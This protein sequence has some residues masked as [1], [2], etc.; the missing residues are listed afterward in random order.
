MI[1][2]VKVGLPEDILQVPGNGRGHQLG[3]DVSPVTFLDLDGD[4]A[5]LL[6]G[7]DLGELFHKQAQGT[8]AGQE[9]D[10]DA[11]WR[12]GLFDHLFDDDGLLDDLF[13]GDND[14]LGLAR[15]CRRSGGSEAQPLQ[16]LAARNL[17]HFN[18]PHRTLVKRFSTR[19]TERISVAS[20]FPALHGHRRQ[21]DGT[22]F[23]P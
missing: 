6:V 12:D 3:R 19:C 23:M 9:A 22:S 7:I 18:P 17:G 16:K 10:L 15:G 1:G 21:A 2:D 11:F 13:F 5:F 4:R 8:D 14:G 20:S